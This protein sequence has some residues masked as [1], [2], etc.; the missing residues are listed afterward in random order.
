MYFSGL[1]H[2]LS[3]HIKTSIKIKI[4]FLFPFPTHLS[5]S[6]GIPLV[7]LPQLTPQKKRRKKNTLHFCKKLKK[8]IIINAC[9]IC[10]R[11][12]SASAPTP[13]PTSARLRLLCT[14]TLPLV[15]AAVVVAVA[16]CCCCCLFSFFGAFACSSFGCK[17]HLG[18]NN[19]A[20]MSSPRPLSL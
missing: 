19:G 7:S 11:T 5:P 2:I 13:A 20:N 12:M 15:A 18:K 14:H 10:H 6:Q 8:T 16:C 1:Y 3:C 9:W 4:V 17:M